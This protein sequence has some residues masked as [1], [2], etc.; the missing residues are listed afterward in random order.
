[1]LNKILLLLTITLSLSSCWTKKCEKPDA[2][3][4]SWSMVPEGRTEPFQFKNPKGKIY[5]FN[6]LPPT[7]GKSQPN[8]S[9]SSCTGSYYACNL[10]IGSDEIY[11]SVDRDNEGNHLFKILNYDSQ[12]ATIR[13]NQDSMIATFPPQNSKYFKINQVLI[14]KNKGIKLFIANDTIYERIN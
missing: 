5:S 3:H 2:E 13:M 14:L 6:I 9:T 7:F 10:N 11:W 4:C 1:M 8:G 12:S